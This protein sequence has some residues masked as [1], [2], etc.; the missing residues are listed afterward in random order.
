MTK[1][2]IKGT[3]VDMIAQL[4]ISQDPIQYASLFFP[5]RLSPF[6]KQLSDC[7]INTL[8]LEREIIYVRCRKDSKIT[9]SPYNLKLPYFGLFTA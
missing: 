3:A 5:F 8:Q 6:S 1:I 7:L 2:K 9:P 4:H